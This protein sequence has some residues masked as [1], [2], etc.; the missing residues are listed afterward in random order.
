MLNVVSFR[1]YSVAGTDAD[2]QADLS[3]P[4]ENNV[5]RGWLA[6]PNDT[7]KP[8]ITHAARRPPR[9]TQPPLQDAPAIA[10]LPD[11]IRR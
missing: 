3:S 11:L 4:P 10:R 7:K 9:D 8:W 2:K 1:P 6:A 5:I